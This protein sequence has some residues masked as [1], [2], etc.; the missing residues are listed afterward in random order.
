[1]VNTNE[2]PVD[3]SPT[4]VES[5]E[6]IVDA[7]YELISFGPG[8]DPA[9][10]AFR[11]L[12]AEQCVLALRL[13]PGDPAISILSLD[14]YVR[15]QVREDMKEEGYAERPLERSFSR[16]GDIASA[17][18]RFEMLFGAGET[19][20]GLDQFQMVRR[21]GRWWIVAVTGEIKPGDATLA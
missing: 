21:E 11:G 18:V 5:P 7:I 9:W 6:A 4:C 17:T 8:G 14:D 13:F 19:Y 3:I 1:M 2:I 20:L 16:T 12:F 10:R 15:K